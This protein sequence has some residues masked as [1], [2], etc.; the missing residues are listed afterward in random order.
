MFLL[1]SFG[2]YKYVINSMY[3]FV[4]EQCEC[5]DKCD[6]KCL[7]R[8][9]HIE[10]YSSNKSCSLKLE[11]SKGNCNVGGNCGNRQLQNKNYIKVKPFVEN[12]MG[13]GLKTAEAVAKGTLVIE[14][15]GEVIN[16]ATM[17]V[18]TLFIALN[19]STRSLYE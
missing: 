13:W 8:L 16:D 1:C 12:G 14:Y 19:C 11:S 3:V 5:K 17:Q 4:E 2:V 18:S 9:L 15:V 7:N 6:E 10:C